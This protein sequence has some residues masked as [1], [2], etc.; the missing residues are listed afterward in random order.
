[1]E[2]SEKSG[3]SERSVLWLSVERS[4]W[5]VEWVFVGGKSVEWVFVGVKAV[6]WV[7]VG[8]K[9]VEWVFV[10]EKSV[11]SVSGVEMWGESVFELWV[12]ASVE[13]VLRDMSVDE[14]IPETE[15]ELARVAPYGSE[16]E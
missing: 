10:A 13:L 16:D 2:R 5:S 14:D 15:D 6:E 12:F 11:G 7:F 3:R 4:E 9:A 8:V 1:M